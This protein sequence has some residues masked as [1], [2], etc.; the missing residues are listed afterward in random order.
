[1]AAGAVD[2]VV[3]RDDHVVVRMGRDDLLGP[4]DDRLARP[5]FEDHHHPLPAAGGVGG[6]DVVDLVRL[7]RPADRGVARRR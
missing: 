3:G 6:V 1:M 4:V 7:V 2:V 5:Q